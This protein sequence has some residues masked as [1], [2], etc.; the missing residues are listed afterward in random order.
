M[1]SIIKEKE[2]KHEALHTHDTCSIDGCCS[3]ECGSDESILKSKSFLAGVILFV[4]GT[5]M[6]LIATGLPAMA[7]PAVFL[8][9]YLL[10]GKDV[11]L[12]A[13]RNIWKGKVFDENFLMAIASIGAFIIGE[14]P[15]R[16]R[17]M[18]F[19][20]AASGE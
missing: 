9:A 2:R 17:L 7:E 10:V 8:A 4:L 1:S 11:L 13:G 3:G 5:G 16:L 12:T 15:K 6:G 14:Y 18:L 20:E 19:I